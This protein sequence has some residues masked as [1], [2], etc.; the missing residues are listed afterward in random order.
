[1]QVLG[2]PATA[3][4]DVY[5]LGVVAYECLS[6]RRPF[7]GDNPF[8]I[9]LRRLREAPPQLPP[10]V[11]AQ[12]RS[13]VERALAAEPEQRWDSAAALAAAARRAAEAVRTGTPTPPQGRTE[14][15][16]SPPVSPPAPPLAPP[17][18]PPPFTPP[19]PPSAPPVTPPRPP[20]TPVPLAATPPPTPTRPGYGPPP[21]YP[22]PTGYRPPRA[23]A[24]GNLGVLSMVF[25][26]ASIPLACC[27]I[28]VPLAIAAVVMGV[29]GLRKAS[30]GAPENRG[31]LI[32]GITCGAVGLVM[33]LLMIV[34]GV[35][36]SFT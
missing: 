34:F 15:A 33:M 21:P 18:A 27:Y 32:A 31:Q 35:A 5:A 6:G 19:P 36:D 14:V 28:G 30:V 11:P 26:I 24:G 9:A 29:V 1:E 25:G 10:D 22:G 20:V 2:R 17:P 3:R 13:V 8:D 12:V 7:D 4:S 16:Q 23:R